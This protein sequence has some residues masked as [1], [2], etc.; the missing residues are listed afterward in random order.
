MKKYKFDRLAGKGNW[1]KVVKTVIEAESKEEAL[2]IFEAKYGSR[3]LEK[4]LR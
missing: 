4:L 1:I 2:E 3:Y